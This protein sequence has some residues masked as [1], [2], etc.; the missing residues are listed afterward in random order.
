MA[1]S[2]NSEGSGYFQSQSCRFG[3]AQTFIEQQ[4]GT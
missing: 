3:A 1:L 4:N 2:K